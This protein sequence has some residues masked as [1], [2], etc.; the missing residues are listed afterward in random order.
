VGTNYNLRYKYILICDCGLMAII[1]TWLAGEYFFG[2]IILT[3]PVPFVLI[4]LG[5]TV[6]LPV[7]GYYNHGQLILT[8]KYDNI[9]PARR[10]TRGNN[11]S[12][13]PSK[14]QLSTSLLYS[15]TFFVRH[16][17][18]GI[19][20]R[21]SWRVWCRLPDFFYNFLKLVFT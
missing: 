21:A 4:S 16:S 10:A 20:C 3:K 15:L 12:T 11:E 8:L 6:S 9:T 18:F 13:R 1:L 7:F 14:H 19:N 2:K 17:L 5:H